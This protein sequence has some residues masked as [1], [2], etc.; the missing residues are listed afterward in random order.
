[1]S[2]LTVHDPQPPP[3]PAR[4]RLSRR[5]RRARAVCGRGRARGSWPVLVVMAF[6]RPGHRARIVRGGTPPA[7]EP[8]RDRDGPR[9][10]A[11]YGAL[12]DR[13]A[14]RQAR[15]A[16][17]GDRRSARRTP[18]T[19]PFR[20]QP[21][22]GSCSTSTPARSCGSTTRY[23]RLRIA[24]LTKMMTALLT[25]TSAPPDAPVLI[26]KEAV[27]MPGS[28]VGVL[29]LGKHVQARDAPL[30]P[31][32]ALGQ[33]RCGRARRSTSRTPSTTSSRA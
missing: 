8:C 20:E 10:G 29:P 25:V 2:T 6:A 4:D 23:T 9:G 27:D 26:T 13:V 15:L 33:R 22:A 18:C 24:S 30:R 16:L 11:H 21:H 5:R 7:R 14:A 31:A 32:A 17:D 3:P 1:M 28:K 19:P 12:T